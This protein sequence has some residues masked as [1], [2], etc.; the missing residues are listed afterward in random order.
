MNSSKTKWRSNTE[1]HR[2]NNFYISVS[3][4]LQKGEKYLVN[5]NDAS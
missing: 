5:D 4:E 2:L 3:S 1:L